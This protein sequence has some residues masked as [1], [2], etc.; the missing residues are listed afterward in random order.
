MIQHT[1]IFTV[2]GSCFVKP[3]VFQA[4]SPRLN[5]YDGCGEFENT[6][7]DKTSRFTM[8]AG[9]ERV[10]SRSLPLAA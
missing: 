8:I 4:S 1:Q 3:H 9:T 2:F 6:Y 7:E 5:V 10:A